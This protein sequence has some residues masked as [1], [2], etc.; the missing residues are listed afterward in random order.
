MNELDSVVRVWAA[1]YYLAL[2]DARRAGAGVFV[3]DML[4]LLRQ[5]G[6]LE[7]AGHA[8]RARK[9]DYVVADPTAAQA[10]L[11][12][13]L[14]DHYQRAGRQHPH[15]A[16][17]ATAFADTIIPLF[18]HDTVA[19]AVHHADNRGAAAERLAETELSWWRKA[20]T[21]RSQRQPPRRRLYP[22]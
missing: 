13:V 9:A 12:A 1:D 16:E 20:Q 22:C 5:P 18:R 2:P 4:E 17:E 21:V 7:R 19:F 11:R 14:I 6:V 10:S 3:G 8:A 15:L